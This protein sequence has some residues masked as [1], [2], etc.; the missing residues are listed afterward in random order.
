MNVIV[1]ARYN[2]PDHAAHG[3]YV[4]GLLAG[5]VMSDTVTVALRRPAP[6]E[7]ELLV[8]PDD[9]RG[10]G[11]RLLDGEG[12]VVAEALAGAIVV[13]A[14]PPVPY[15]EALKAAEGYRAAEPAGR[16]PFPRCFVC[17]PLREQGD[18][19]RLEPGPAGEGLV[20]APWTPGEPPAPEIMWAVLGCPGGL[21][22]AAPGPPI[23]LGTMT[24]QVTELPEAGER[25]VVMGLARSREGRKRHAATA[26]YGEDGRLLGRAEQI[27]IEYPPGPADA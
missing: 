13:P 9:D 2:G 14:V 5:Q 21:A 19:M 27:W 22:S 8:F 12:R 24:A 18:G 4:A 20:A 1:K 15:E 6:L 23:L 25:C 26:A 10:I 7:T 17:G 11:A 3:G 16:H